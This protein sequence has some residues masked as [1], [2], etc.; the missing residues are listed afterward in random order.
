ML[1]KIPPA[2]RLVRQLR[3]TYKPLATNAEACCTLCE[4]PAEWVY[5]DEFQ[6]GNPYGLCAH[7]DQV[8]QELV[9][10]GA[11]VIASMWGRLGPMGAGLTSDDHV[12][13]LLVGGLILGQGLPLVERHV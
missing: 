7:H 6:P 1:I 2:R 10:A 8:T 5:P 11:S 9:K 3:N 13:C 12:L 4:S